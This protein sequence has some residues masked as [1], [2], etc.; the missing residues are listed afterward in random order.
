MRSMR[1]V[2]LRFGYLCVLSAL[3]SCSIPVTDQPPAAADIAERETHVAQV[4]AKTHTALAP[5]ATATRTRTETPAPSPSATPS[6][7]LVPTEQPTAV[8]PYSLAYVQLEENGVSNVILQGPGAP[9]RQLLTRFVE[10]GSIS[11]LGWSDDGQWLVFVSSQDYIHSR[12]NERNIFIVRPDGT[13]LS[14][15]TGEYLDPDRAPGPYSALSG[16]IL[17]GTGRC[18]VCAQ[19]ANPVM[20]SDDGSFEIAGVSLS[21][22]WAR[23]VC[24]EGDRVLQGDCDLVPLDDSFAL[25]EI[26]V[27]PQG[28]GWQ[29]AE[30]YGDGGA[31]AGTL[32]RWTESEEGERTYEY[33][34]VISSWAIDSSTVLSRPL[35]LTIGGLDWSP[36]GET[37][38]VAATTEEGTGLWLYKR[39]GAPLQPVV[40]MMNP[41]QIALS[42]AN[43]AW[44][45][46]GSS[47]AFELRKWY[48]WGD[49]KYK[50]DL[51]SVSL[52]N[53]TDPLHVINNEWG[54][55]AS[56]PV[57]SSDGKEIYFQLS[58]EEPAADYRSKTNGN[59][60]RVALGSAVGTQLT[61][62]GDSYLPAM[63]SAI[64]PDR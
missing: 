62:D 55:H 16:N 45:P 61:L 27:A 51:I 53:P 39:E 44:S 46:D 12:A 50:T 40:E 23:A 3:L 4:L 37:V 13:E 22:K 20:A 26:T 6:P 49:H 21:S 64:Q 35:T 54:N 47:I 31:F 17:G 7:T 42:A 32:Y 52:D 5:T 38:I 48:W 1:R 14:M 10:P 41:D 11:D 25:A 2:A 36:D 59:I 56:H 58:I 15:V 19:G 8:P 57:W 24:R 34:G 60:W 9:E 28:K 63:S 43:P 29:Q 33:Q 30:L 18:I